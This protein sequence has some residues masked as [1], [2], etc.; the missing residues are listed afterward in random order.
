M[1]DIPHHLIYH[2]QFPRKDISLASRAHSLRT[3]IYVA[4]NIGLA[5]YVFPFQKLP[6]EFDLIFD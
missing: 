1:F 4:K 6:I 3:Q 5:T 2:I